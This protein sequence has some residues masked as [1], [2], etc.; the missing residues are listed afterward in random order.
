MKRLPACLA[1]LLQ[2]KSMGLVDASRAVFT[3][4]IGKLGAL[5]IERYVD[6][7]RDRLGCKLKILCRAGPVLAYHG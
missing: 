4:K 5:V 7:V 2:A 6:D 1:G 3:G